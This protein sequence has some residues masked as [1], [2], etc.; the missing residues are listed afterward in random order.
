M[1][2]SITILDG[3]P[4]LGILVKSNNAWVSSRALAKAFDKRHDHI[5]RDLEDINEKVDATFWG[6]NFMKKTYKSRGKSYPI[7]LMTRKGFTL[8]ALGFTGTKAMR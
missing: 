4:E 7:Y 6:A 2:Q 3:I 5:L 1:T 8:V